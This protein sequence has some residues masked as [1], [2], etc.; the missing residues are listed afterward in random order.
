MN[1]LWLSLL[2][3][4]SLSACRK[5][6][7]LQTTP[8]PEFL[9]DEIRKAKVFPSGASFFARLKKPANVRGGYLS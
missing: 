7:T 6:T 3:I 2:I 5:E 4:T 8:Y 9:N 1:R